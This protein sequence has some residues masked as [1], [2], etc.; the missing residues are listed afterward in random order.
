MRQYSSPVIQTHSV[1]ETTL[2]KQWSIV[3]STPLNKRIHV[4]NL[5]FG[6]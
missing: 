3:E 5:G 6:L 4:F 1:L 2:K